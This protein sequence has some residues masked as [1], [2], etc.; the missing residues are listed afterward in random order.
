LGAGPNP[1]SSNGDPGEFAELPGVASWPAELAVSWQDWLGGPVPLGFPG[2]AYAG[3]AAPDDEDAAQTACGE[4]LAHHDHIPF[5]CAPSRTYTL[6]T[7]P[8][9]GTFVFRRIKMRYSAIAVTLDP[10]GV[11]NY[12]RGNHKPCA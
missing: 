8:S 7:V 4:E 12:L 10:N 3:A 6:N 2:P 5:R 1:G 11:P 9:T